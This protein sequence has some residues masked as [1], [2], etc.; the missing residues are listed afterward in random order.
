MTRPE[1]PEI[2]ASQRPMGT[3][4]PVALLHGMDKRLRAYAL[5]A[6]ASGVGFLAMAQPANAKVVHTPADISISNGDLF[7]DLNC[8]QKVNFWLA[9][10]LEVSFYGSVREFEINGSAN[11]SVIPSNGFAAALPAGAVIGPSRSFQNVHRGELILA[12]VF[13]T[14]YGSGTTGNW[15]HKRA[16]L[17][18]KFN[19]QGQVHYG[20]AE[21]RVVAS[22]DQYSNFHIDANLSGYAYENN[23]N[24]SIR[25]GQTHGTDEGSA[26]PDG[27]GPEAGTLGALARGSAKQGHCPDSEARPR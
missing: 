5:V 24:Q 7:L 9:D 13:Q 12:E 15:A 19:I 22:M 6:T 25:A 1:S 11:A 16:Y 18:L 23:P 21:M 8:G 26:L 20:W 27:F 2:A 14:G 17:G 4:A 10:K 3:R